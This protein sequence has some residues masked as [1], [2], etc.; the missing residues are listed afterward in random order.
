MVKQSKID[1]KII[2]QL[3]NI[4]AGAIHYTR[5]YHRRQYRKRRKAIGLKV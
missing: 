5:W 4:L 1:P 2:A 3:K